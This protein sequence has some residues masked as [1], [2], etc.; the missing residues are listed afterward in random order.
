[1]S[2]LADWFLTPAERGNEFT[3]L[4]RRHGDGTAWTEGNEVAVLVDG[5]SYF[6]RLHAALTG[7]EP[8]ASV[9][10]TDWEG[11]ADERLDGPGT[12]LGGMLRE[13]VRR[14]VALRGL[15]WRS[16]PRQAHFAE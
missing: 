3:T 4:D 14:G 9:W 7:L 8:G 16:H 15:L 6:A 2:A 11:H 1:M 5:A 13:L 12:D 10:L